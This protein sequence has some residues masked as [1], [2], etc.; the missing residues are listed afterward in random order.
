M[1]TLIVASLDEFNQSFNPARTGT[2][3]DVILDLSGGV[4]FLLMALLYRRLSDR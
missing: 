1:A 2:P 4:V 3:I